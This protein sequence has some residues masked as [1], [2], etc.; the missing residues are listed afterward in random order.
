MVAPVRFNE[1]KTLG[2]MLRLEP[3]FFYKTLSLQAEKMFSNRVSF[4]ANLHLKQG[5]NNS[6][7]V[8]GINIVD[9]FNKSGYLLELA[10]KYYLNAEEPSGLYFQCHVGF[11]DL[12]YDDGTWR[13]GG[14]NK[15]FASKMNAERSSL[16]VPGFF[17][18]GL[19]VGYQQILINQYLTVN[20][21]GGLQVQ[22]DSEGYKGLW[23]FAPS[24]G[25]YF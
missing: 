25:V 19:A 24:F 4:G 12:L 22:N 8:N 13:P 5:S 2:W 16:P 14:I 1:R 10:T 18:S 7:M 17:R 6:R 3:T 21:M 15:T 9:H 23:F 20:V 11:G